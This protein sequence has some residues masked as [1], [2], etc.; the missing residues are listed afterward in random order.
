[1]ET[2]IIGPGE[3]CVG[4]SI[5]TAN[6]SNVDINTIMEAVFTLILFTLFVRLTVKMKIVAVRVSVEVT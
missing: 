3:G 6:G 2:V 4:V 1:M 5:T